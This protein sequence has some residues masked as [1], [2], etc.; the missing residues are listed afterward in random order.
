MYIGQV[1]KLT[2]AT[3]KAIR[4]YEAIGLMAPPKRLGKYRY[5]SDADIKVIRLIKSA[6]K[7]GFKL[8]EIETIVKKTTSDNP[9]PYAELIAAIEKKRQQIRSEIK[10]LTSTDKGLAELID[11]LRNQKCSC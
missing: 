7:Y 2:G 10:Q 11:H 5:F 1:A 4:H 6:Q 8:S 9:F 3:P